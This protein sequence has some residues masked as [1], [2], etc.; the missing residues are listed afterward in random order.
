MNEKKDRVTGAFNAVR[1][2]VEEGIILVRTRALL[3]CIP[4]LDSLKP[5]I[6]DQKICIEIKE[7]SKFLQ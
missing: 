5:A 4:A 1:A 6:E 2:V 3:Q 7:H